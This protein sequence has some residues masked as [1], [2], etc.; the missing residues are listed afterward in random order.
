MFARLGF[1]VLGLALFFGLVATLALARTSTATSS[2]TPPRAATPATPS[3]TA[4]ASPPPI[5]T[6]PAPPEPLPAGCAPGASP[7]DLAPNAPSGLW[8]VVAA[9]PNLPGLPPA[10]VVFRWTDNSG[11]ELCFALER[12][13]GHGPWQWLSAVQADQ[14]GTYG[15][16]LASGEPVC[17]RVFAGNDVGRS[18]YSNEACVEPQ[19]HVTA[20]PTPVITPVGCQIPKP[21][22]TPTAGR[23]PAAPSEL[24]AEL[25][26]D[27]ELSSGSA[28]QLTWQDNAD[29]E[30]CFAIAVRMQGE[31][32][33][34]I[35][36]FAP[37]DG[38]GTGPMTLEDFPDRTGLHC[39]QV[40]YG[41]IAGQSHSDEACVSVEVLPVWG[42]STPAPTQS[43]VATPTPSP[44]V[45]PT[46][47]PLLCTLD[48][49]PYSELGPAA[50]TNLT[51]T[52]ISDVT[53]PGGYR[54]DLAWQDNA[55]DA[56]CFKVQRRDQDGTWHGFT[57]GMGGADRA[58]DA[59]PWPGACYRAWVANEHGR[60][61]YS[62]EACAAPAGFPSGCNVEGLVGSPGAPNPPSDL[63]VALRDEPGLPQPSF[64]DLAWRDN[65]TDEACFVL[66]FEGPWWA[67]EATEPDQTTFSKA[68][69][70]EQWGMAGYWCYRVSAANEWGRSQPSNEVCLDIAP[71]AAST[72]G[73]TATAAA[74]AGLRAAPATGGG[75]GTA[76]AWWWWALAGAGSALLGL[77]ALSLT[78]VARRRH[79]PT[80]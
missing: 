34:I 29:S 45:T 73:A 27:P 10:V 32:I 44:P 62:D 61:A 26:P 50:P 37:V 41:D 58:V 9:N 57:G 40:Y 15:D 8:A 28:V 14:R 6:H 51:A 68:A 43:T 16:G 20:T 38:S 22:A 4:T 42:T 18:E 3:A 49:P 11:D 17:F 13:V 80:R 12:R 56:L 78:G 71:G 30:T 36:V 70:A 72:S 76:L 7:S 65:S 53:I 2:A 75:E 19:E 25:V 54:V 60:S 66:L 64:V 39:Y 59:Q 74:G 69:Y 35:G 46:P 24:R 55:A 21:G 67:T 31:L 47:P 48:D 63:T 79:H 5:P 1:A 23:G 33:R 77:A 52:L